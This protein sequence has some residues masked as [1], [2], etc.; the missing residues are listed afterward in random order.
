[1]ASMSPQPTSMGKTP[2][3]DLYSFAKKFSILK[4]DPSQ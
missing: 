4:D 2:M 3:W 1:M